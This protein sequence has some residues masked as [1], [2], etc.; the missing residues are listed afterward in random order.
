MPKTPRKI[1]SRRRKTPRRGGV[2]SGE[3]A[4]ATVDAHP[5][6][7]VIVNPASKFVVATYWWGRGRQNPNTQWPCPEMY[8]ERAKEQLESE[9]GEE[10]PDY[11]AF[12]ENEFI[13]LRN[14]VTGRNNTPVDKSDETKQKWNEAKVK[15]NMV[16]K[17]FFEKQSVK[18]AIRKYVEQYKKEPL[19]PEGTSPEYGGLMEQPMIFETMIGKWEEACKAANCN[20]LSVEY[21]EFT[22]NWPKFYQSAINAKPMFIKKALE[23]C[24]GRG[25]LYVDGDMLVHKYPKIFDLQNVDIMAHGWGSD[26]RTNI[27]FK[28]WQCYDPYIFETSGGTMFYANTPAAIR[29]L[30]DWNTENNKKSMKERLKIVFYQ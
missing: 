4:Q 1:P 24:G 14:A 8:V 5:L 19:A 6:V 29:T 2:E 25:I 26:P 27:R 30:D 23:S 15:R 21:P 9:I 28:T 12:I 7:P 18:D 13:P 10:D 16:L 17:S 20:Y 11:A 3:Y 22:I